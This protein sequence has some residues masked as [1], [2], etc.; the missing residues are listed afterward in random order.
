[1]F[2]SNLETTEKRVLTQ[3]EI[4]ISGGCDKGYRIPEGLRKLSDKDG[5]FDTVNLAIERVDGEL[6]G[7]P[8]K[9]YYS[10]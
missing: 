8:A 1:M 10:F 5:W 7:R 6:S 4:F 3:S 2:E 9:K